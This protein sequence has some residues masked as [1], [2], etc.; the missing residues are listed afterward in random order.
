MLQEDLKH[1]A[2][3]AQKN[4]NVSFS[5]SILLNAFVSQEAGDPELAE[6]QALFVFHVSKFWIN[7]FVSQEAGDPELAEDQA[8]FVFHVSKFWINAF[9]SQEAGDPELAEDQAL[10][11][12]HVSK[13]WIVLP[14]FSRKPVILSWHVVRRFL[15]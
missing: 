8:L 12:F 6:D 3:Q 11:V 10:F 2:E 14:L 15:F 4:F 1:R 5:W 13:F 9:V 7:A